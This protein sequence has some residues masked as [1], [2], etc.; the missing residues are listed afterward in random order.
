[1]GVESSRI[2]T[3]GY[4]ESKPIEDN[5]TAKGR[6]QNR[7]AEINRSAQLKIN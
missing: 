4:G 1:L 7:R 5:K 6:K 3:I 2:E